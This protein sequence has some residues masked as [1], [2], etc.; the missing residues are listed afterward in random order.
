MD[1][2]A[3]EED[4]GDSGQSR[5]RLPAP[6]L[7]QV[8]TGSLIDG[9]SSLDDL[10][11]RCLLRRRSWWACRIEEIGKGRQKLYWCEGLCQ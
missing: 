7:K 2:D 11:M 9:A 8:D 5:L 1:E 4:R 6:H 10:G 3:D